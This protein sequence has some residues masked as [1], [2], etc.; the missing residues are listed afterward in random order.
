MR[1]SINPES[2]ASDFYLLNFKS[3]TDW[4][5]EGLK[6]IGKNIGKQK[7]I[8]MILIRT[9]DGRQVLSISRKQTW[10]QKDYQSKDWICNW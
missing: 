10:G 8:E 9:E 6:K 1:Q 3:D 2:E 7:I 4:Q 5:R